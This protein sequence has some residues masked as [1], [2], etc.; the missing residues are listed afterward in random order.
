MKTFNSRYLTYSEIAQEFVLTKNFQE[1]L[2]PC[3]SILL[4]TRGCGKTTMLKMLHPAAV[5]EYQNVHSEFHLE[6]Y[7]VYIPADRQ[8]SLILEQLDKET[9]HIEFYEKVS[10][11]LVNV[12]ILLAFID[13]LKVLFDDESFGA[14]KKTEYLSLLVNYWKLG[15]SIPPIIDIIRLN[16]KG[17]II[18]IKNAISDSDFSFVFPYVCK[19][20]FEDTIALAVELFNSLF[21]DSCKKWALCFDEMEIAPEWL[22]RK[23]VNGCLRSIDQTLLF[24]ITATPDWKVCNNN[25]KS[26]TQGND[27]E[28]IKCWNYDYS[29]TMEWRIFCD[30]IIESQVLSKYGVTQDEFIS[31]LS[32]PK[33]HELNFFFHE[34]PKVDK[35]FSEV[36]QKENYDENNG[37]I[38]IKNWIQR[39]K[40]Y[41]YPVLLCR[42]SWFTQDRQYGIPFENVYLGDWLLYKMSD[43]NPRIFCNILGDIVL[44]LRST[45]GNLMPK[46]PAL[47][48]IV[49][50]YSKHFYEGSSFLLD[51]YKTEYGDFTF[52][53]LINIIGWY[54]NHELLSDRYNP[55]PIT[56]FTLGKSSSLQSFVKKALQQGVVVKVEDQQVE[57]SGSSDGI[58]RLSYMLYPY[59]HIIQSFAKNIISLEEILTDNLK[60]EDSSD[61]TNR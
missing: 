61:F 36:F 50:D 46:L 45:K 41:K 55:S 32:D 43:G 25:H 23:I 57:T 33:K 40:K 1:L 15:K 60:N 30:S 8:W 39:K 28:F 10:K 52:E 44:S 37:V 31:L 48:D 56:M 13:T 16:L 42:Y 38:Q 19:S 34:L 51:E 26:P 5:R 20:N 11:S 24:K 12:N 6:F 2:K 29:S 54:F 27:F 58:Y 4:G 59:F 53:E 21:E 17:M 35:G 22:Q 47:R 14:E 49:T 18:D 7:G 3:H 9:E